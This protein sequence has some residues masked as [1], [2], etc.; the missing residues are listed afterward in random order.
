MVTELDRANLQN[1]HSDG[2]KT[3]LTRTTYIVDA[4]KINTPI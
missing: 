4:V 3:T 1:T 2:H